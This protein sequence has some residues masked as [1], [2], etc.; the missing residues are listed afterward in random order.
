MMMAKRKVEFEVK[1]VRYEGT[2]TLA[3]STVVLNGTRS[4]ASQIIDDCRKLWWDHGRLTHPDEE[5][6]YTWVP[7]RNE[8]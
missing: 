4:I 1:L 3:R 8:A 5:G 6:V 7:G 2:D